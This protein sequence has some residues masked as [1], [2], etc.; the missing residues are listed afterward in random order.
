VEW[1]ESARELVERV[2]GRNKPPENEV[3]HDYVLV[4]RGI[5]LRSASVDDDF[6]SSTNEIFKKMGLDRR[7]IRRGL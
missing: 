7:W 1:K 6:A 4:E 5:V 3:E 2:L